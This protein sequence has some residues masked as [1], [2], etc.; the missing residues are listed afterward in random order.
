MLVKSTTTLATALLVTSSLLFTQVSSETFTIDPWE[1]TDEGAET[2]ADLKS[3]YGTFTAVVGDTVIFNYGFEGT[4]HDVWIHGTGTC[5]QGGNPQ[6]QRIKGTTGPGIYKFVRRDCESYGKKI[7]FVCDVGLHCENGQ[8]VLV[9]V[10]CSHSDRDATQAGP[11][12]VPD[13]PPPSVPDDNDPVPGEDG[14]GEDGGDGD[15]EDGDSSGTSGGSSSGGSGND[16]DSSTGSGSSATSTTT[17][18]M[19]TTTTTTAMMI[20]GTTIAA[21]ISLL[22]Q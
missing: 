1:R 21:T 5:E 4:E 3:D 2:G 15:G 6:P 8:N 20:A 19:M 17:L 12:A 10:F 11:N 9:Y 7:L 18:S 16:P 22:L 13:N 14:Q